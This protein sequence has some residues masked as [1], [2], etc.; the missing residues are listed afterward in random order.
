MS[1][2]G[3]KPIKVPSGVKI[4]LN[5][6]IVEVEGG[7]GKLSWNIPSGI[8]AKLEEETLI[9]ER[10][11]DEKKVKALHGLARSVISNMVTGVSDGFSRT[12]EIVGVGYRAEAM[13]SNQIKFNLGYSN[14]VEFTIPEGISAEFEERGTRLILKGIDKQVLGQT[15]ARI[16]ELRP[17]DSYKGKGVRYST[18]KLKLKPGKAGGKG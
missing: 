10:D 12:L 17:P 4:G 16:R 13:G 11:N 8:N 9:I 14:P 3:R 7:K 15:A 6:G 2:I 18:E 1:R 5:N